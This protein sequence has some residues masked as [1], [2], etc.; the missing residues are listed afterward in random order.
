MN[1]NQCVRIEC[2]EAEQF[3]R[4]QPL[5]LELREHHAAISP[6]WRE[7]FLSSS[8]ENRKNGLLRKAVNGLAVLLATL[9]GRD[10]G[11]CICTINADRQGEVD[12]MFVT[13]K[14]RRRG[15]GRALMSHSMRWLGDRPTSAIIVDVLYA[16]DPALRL[17]ES[18]GFHGRTIRLRHVPK[19]TA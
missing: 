9:D 18:F 10:V 6:L 11:Y 16:N 15:V 5:W 4:V 3:D 13:E 19:G 17:Y 8:F 14:S 1:S 2:G 7:D 12:S